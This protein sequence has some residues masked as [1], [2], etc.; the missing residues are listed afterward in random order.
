MNFVIFVTTLRKYGSKVM[1]YFRKVDFEHWTFS[2]L[3][4][5][6]LQKKWHTTHIAFI[7]GI[8]KERE[9]HTESRVEQRI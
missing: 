3:Q 1:Y 6:M 7:V 9:R 2:K 8:I 5:Y 4:R